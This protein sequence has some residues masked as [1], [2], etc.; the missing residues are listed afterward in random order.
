[1]CPSAIHSGLISRYLGGC[2]SLQPLPFQ[3][4]QSTL[5]G[6]NS[7]G[8]QSTSFD[9]DY[10][11]AYELVSHT[12]SGCMDLHPIISGVNA[13]YLLFVT[14][15]LS[16]SPPVLYSI[17]V[18]L[19]YAQIVLIS[20]PP[21]SPPYWDT[22]FSRLIP[23]LFASFFFWKTAFR[24]TLVAFRN[25][26]VETAIWQGLGFWLGIESSTIFSKL[27]IQRLGYGALSG[28]G[29]ITLIV[30]IV[31]VAVVVLIQAWQMRKYGLLQYYLVR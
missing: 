19:G 27:P 18:I 17:L 10:P 15:F 16:P 20:N 12:S 1:M 29:V 8:V 3:S 2:V 6:S 14:L 7:H 25:L 26:P 4:L 28:S 11:G 23:V 5:I 9:P 22:V 21:Y 13:F 24:R 31:L 30:I